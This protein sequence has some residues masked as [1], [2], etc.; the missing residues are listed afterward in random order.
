MKP[1][2]REFETMSASLGTVLPDFLP[3]CPARLPAALDI[4]MHPFVDA[5]TTV[6]SVAFLYSPQT[7]LASVAA[8]NM[9]DAR[10][11]AP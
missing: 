9:H 4:A 7:T 3:H 6:S 10:D 2:D 1:I 11:V 8:L 5:L